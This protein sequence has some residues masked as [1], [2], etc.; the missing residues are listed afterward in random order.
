MD[1]YITYLDFLTKIYIKLF[2]E[3][4]IF[5]FITAIILFILIKISKKTGLIDYPTLRSSHTKPTPVGGGLALVLVLLASNFNLAKD[6]PEFFWGGLL[7]ATIGL[8]DDLKPMKVG[9]RLVTQML[10]VG[11]TIILLPITR[12]LLNMPIFLFKLILFFA[13]VWFIN[14]YNFM[15]GID[16]L[17]GG[18]ANA[19]SVGFLFCLQNTVMIE[20]WNI[21]IYQHIIYITLPF[22]IFNWQPAKIF[23]G[24]IGSTFLGFTFFCL[25]L[26]GLIFGYNIMYSFVIIMS[27]FWIDATITLI[28]RYIKGKK[29]FKAHKEHAFQKAASIFGHWRV[30]LFIITVTLFWLN[31]I[32]QLTMVHK[33]QAPLITLF[34]IFPVLLIILIFKPGLPIYESSRI[35]LLLQSKFKLSSSNKSSV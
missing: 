1:I 30:T 5:F 29:I 21:D 26:R 8:K 28:R 3:N 6:C 34:G 10:A 20:Q 9:P 31:P 17:A 16:G 19:A 22:L 14:I 18:Y 24:D 25:G 35:L 12:P 11:I 23:M 15:D 7:T 2:N 27:F 13:G 33:N 4:F 32:A